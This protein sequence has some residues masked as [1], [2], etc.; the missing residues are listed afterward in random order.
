ME[1]QLFV[2]SNVC[3]FWSWS[4]TQWLDDD[5]SG[6]DMVLSEDA[7]IQIPGMHD[8]IWQK[9]IY[10]QKLIDFSLLR[11]PMVSHTWKISRIYDPMTNSFAPGPNF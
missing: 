5:P 10:G 2:A 9:Q 1:K 8:S 7:A 6:F 11:K 4:G 3:T